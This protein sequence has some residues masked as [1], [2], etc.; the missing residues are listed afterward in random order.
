MK[1][2][3]KEGTRKDLPKEV[4]DSSEEVSVLSSRILPLMGSGMSGLVTPQEGSAHAVPQVGATAT[5]PEVEAAMTRAA[6]R[7]QEH[8]PH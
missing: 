4:N 8:G 1:T 5:V 6:G 7:P 2:S 3:S